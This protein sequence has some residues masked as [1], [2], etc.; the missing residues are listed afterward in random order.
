MPMNGKTSGSS[1]RGSRG[2]EVVAWGAD[3]G[4]TP[5]AVVGQNS[6]VL[7]VIGVPIGRLRGDRDSHVTGQLLCGGVVAE[8]RTAKSFTGRGL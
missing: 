3:V 6:T 8:R 4:V 1:W 7:E 2:R 5:A